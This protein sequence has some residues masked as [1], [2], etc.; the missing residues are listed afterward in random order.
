MSGSLTSGRRTT[1]EVRLP[2]PED[3]PAP[4]FYPVVSGRRSW[5]GAD[6]P[7]KYALA[8]TLPSEAVD[9]LVRVSGALA[10]TRRAFSNFRSTDFSDPE[11]TAALA[12]PFC[13]VQNGRGFAI[14]RGL[15]VADLPL[16][17]VKVASSSTSTSC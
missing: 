11:L 4:T 8:F 9:R 5:T 15:P 7:P 12:A 16:D 1:G 10:E 6:L 13:E 14:V 3:H 17:V 2:R